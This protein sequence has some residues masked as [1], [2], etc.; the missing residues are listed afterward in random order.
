M[1]KQIYK[2]LGGAFLFF[3]AAQYALAAEVVAKS[4]EE[5]QAAL[6]KG[7]SVI[8]EKGAEIPVNKTIRFMH[9]GQKIY[10]KDAK[11]ISEYARLKIT[12]PEGGQILSGN[13]KSDIT[14]EKVILDGNRY[15]LPPYGEGGGP[16]LAWF[17][18][19]GAKNQT[20]RNCVF[21]NSRTWSTFKLHE[22]GD[23][24]KIENSI[25]F[26]CGADARGNGRNPQEKPFRWGDGISCAARNSTVANNIVIDPTDV[27]V[28]L[29]CAPGSQVYDNV[30]ASISRESLGGIN[31]VDGLGFYEIGADKLPKDDKTSMRKYDYSGVVVKDNLIDSRGARIHIAVPCGATV[32]VPSDKRTRTFVGAKIFDNILDG[33]ASAYGIIVDGVEDFEI[34][35]NKS[36]GKHSGLADGRWDVLC[37]EPAPFIYNPEYTASSKLQKE[38]KKQERSLQHLLRCNHG[39]VQRGGHFR[40]YRAYSY[41]PEE[42]QA[43]VKT[44]FLEMLGRDATNAEAKKYSRIINEHVLPADE[45][46]WII[47]QTDEFQKKYGK[48]G[49]NDIHNFR[50]QKWFKLF[51]EI[52]GTSESW[53][54]KEVYKAALKKLKTL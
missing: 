52:I 12:S 37:D 16:E 45:L 36:L 50:T 17:G 34:R 11:R 41:G 10:T 1:K 38:F 15:G 30:I 35:G 13:G 43:V 42:A 5:I 14:L 48:I 47:A 49:R 33:E 24:C 21:M 8:L 29:F 39:P 2:L 51:D 27:G 53:K 18:G 40:D 26:G 7:D 20:I 46:R 6:D 4:A 32:W 31:M 25:L 54:A 3:A 9:N 44:A 23:G 19:G 22:G 28:V